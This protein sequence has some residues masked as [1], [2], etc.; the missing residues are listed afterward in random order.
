[1]TLLTIVLAVDVIYFYEAWAVWM[2]KRF[3][4]R[5][6]FHA[7]AHGEAGTHGHGHPATAKPHETAHHEKSHDTPVPDQTNENSDQHS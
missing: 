5:T 4:Y 6:V 7:H 1:M 2:H 3:K